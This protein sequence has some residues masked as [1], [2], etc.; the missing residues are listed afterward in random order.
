[1]LV[2]I[3]IFSIS[4]IHA[5]EVNATD[6]SAL[7]C[8]DDEVIQIEE[9]YQ[10]ESDYSNNLLTNITDS[11]LDDSIKSKSELTSPTTSMYYKGDYAVTLK[12]SNTNAS[13][14]NKNVYFVIN[15]VVYKASTN[16]NGVASVNLKL[17]PGNYVATTYFSGD[18]GYDAS[19]NLISSF[20]VLS[21]IKASNLS[22][23]YKGSK[24]FSATFFNS[25][26]KVL[27]NRNVKITINGK[28]YTKKTNAKG[29][30]SMPVNLKP[31]TYKIISTDPITGYKLTTTFKILSTISSSNL[32]KVK[33]DSKKFKVSFFKSNGKALANKYVKLKISGKTYKIKTDSKGKVILSL[34]GLKTGTHKVVCYNNDG[35]SK[36]YKVVIYK[37]A[38][39]KLK[40]SSYTFFPEDTKEIKA[41]FSTSLDDD[42]N[43]GK[44]IRITI[45][46]ITYSKKTDI[47]GVVSMDLS[48]LEKGVY[49]IEYEYDGN[50][51]FNPATATSYVT[52]LNDTS[53]TSLT[54]EST[55]SFGQGAGTLFQ[56]A[57]TADDVPLIKKQVTFTVHGKT[58]TKTT[59]YDGIASL[60][61]NLNVGNYT[62][63]FKTNDESRIKGT[64][65][66]CEINVF[67]RSGSILT[68]ECG[69]S[70][71]D[72]SQ[73]LK[74]LLT[75]LNGTP[76][77]DGTIRLTI[78]GDTYYGTT[79]SD[80]YAEIETYAAIGKCTVSVKFVGSNEYLPNSTSKDVTVK[81]SK[82]GNG[83]NEKNTIANL[84]AY[85]KSS[86]HCKV[87]DSKI[88]ALVKSLT[89]G[90]T[91][92]VDK[93]KAIFNYVRDTLDY[94]LYFNTKYGAT[95]TLKNKKG[96]C[97]DHTHLL[98]SMFR[99][100]G[101][102]A[103]YVHGICTFNS[104]NTLGHV[105]AQ[106]LID[107]NWVCADATDY[108]NQL[109]KITN[110]HTGS[111]KIRAK[112][113]S[114]PF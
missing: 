50:K 111:Y 65:G 45:D 5:S 48:S 85:L 30:V 26:G 7:N 61:I 47:N 70:F 12:D 16:K 95:G 53:V 51:F 46:G 32:K 67:E 114:L 72:S 20:K 29:I 60:P 18:E 43:S 24:K 106:V 9:S 78:D 89:K 22:K 8:S 49:E 92:P 101:L 40:T 105:W 90:L 35:L 97:V 28:S 93:A 39:T 44:T 100:A 52:I 109:G 37:K 87:G 83:L 112:Y 31:G 11:P 64:S 84:N 33:G 103:R 55:S 10:L 88:K 96:N 63:D 81:L 108:D 77:S 58:Y 62:V 34:N 71:K 25:K 6:L 86:N 42:S 41:K 36:T 107:N 17:A 104:G 69:T 91:N 14:A 94:S 56:V 19:G 38:S 82:F 2:L 74:V 75:D 102:K 98:V 79:E 66:S 80:G 13:L 59:D 73:T 15:D 4:T 3:L 21:T 76:I 110:W 99:T 54:V 68:W 27:A 23:Y 1:M 57:Y 113:S